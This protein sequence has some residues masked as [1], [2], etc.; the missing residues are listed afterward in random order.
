LVV[1]SID[2]DSVS[3]RWAAADAEADR[4]LA[5]EQA[6]VRVG[7]WTRWN[8][9]LGVVTL[10]LAVLGMVV[11]PRGEEDETHFTV[12]MALVG[13]AF[14][15]VLACSFRSARVR[16]RTGAMYPTVTTVLSARERH[17]VA[18]AVD[19]RTAAPVDRL[20]VVRA[21]AV[22][23]SVPDQVERGVWLCALWAAA[24]LGASTE[25][26]PVGWLYVVAGV[27]WAAVTLHAWFDMA[28]IRRALR[29]T[30]A[31]WEAA[32]ARLAPRTRA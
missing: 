2:Q 9:A 11:L 32:A 22:L 31:P 30:P 16:R 19:G 13:L 27:A 29:K 6:L 1:V 21:A 10:V 28:R 24:A 17:A 15:S 14:V 7:A 25:Q 12:S 5:H 3:R 8:V 20:R 26:S 4:V 23:R 18:R